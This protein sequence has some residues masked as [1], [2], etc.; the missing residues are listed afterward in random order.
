MTQQSSESV[1]NDVTT[2]VQSEPGGFVRMIEQPVWQAV[3]ASVV[4]I[5]LFGVLLSG[6]WMMDAI[7]N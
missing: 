6:I 3:F 4:T 7:V 5:S 1:N 2:A